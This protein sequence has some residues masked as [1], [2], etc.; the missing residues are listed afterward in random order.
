MKLPLTSP[1]AANWRRAVEPYVG[2]NARRASF[3]LITTLLP[4]A[5]V[6][7]AAHVIRPYSTALAL[8]LIPLIAGLIVR[9][10]TA[11]PQ[12]TAKE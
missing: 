3:Q 2:P 10:R 11:G 5:L 8:L 12:G 9:T 4:L 7:S 1:E 6:V